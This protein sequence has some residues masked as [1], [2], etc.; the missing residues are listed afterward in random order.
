VLEMKPRRERRHAAPVAADIAGGGREGSGLRSSTMLKRRG[1]IGQEGPLSA[2]SARR[3]RVC[4]SIH[5]G[6]VSVSRSVNTSSELRLHLRGWSY[7]AEAPRSVEIQL[8]SYRCCRRFVKRERW[9]RPES[10]EANSWRRAADVHTCR[11]GA[12]AYLHGVAVC[13]RLEVQC[14]DVASRRMVHLIAG[15]CRREEALGQRG[16]PGLGGEKRSP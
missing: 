10:R 11:H 12:K 15:T 2:K 7:A 16:R 8:C 5:G 13:C 6:G 4:S 1:R 9:V 14:S 3:Q